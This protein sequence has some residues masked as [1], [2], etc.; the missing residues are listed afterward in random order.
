MV[1]LS[2]VRGLALLAGVC[3]A[4]LGLGQGWAQGLSAGATPDVTIAPKSSAVVNARVIDPAKEP[5]ISAEEKLQL[6]RRH[7]K[8]VFVLFQ[9]NRSFDFYFGSYPGADGLYAGPNGPY[10]PAQVAGFTQTIVNTDGTLGTVTPFR[11]PAT[12]TDAAGKTVP[13]FP[14]DIASVDHSHVGIARKIALDADGVAQNTEYALS[15]EGVRVVDGKPSK[16]PTL[17]RKQFGELVMSHVDC[18]TVPF[19]W[20]YADRFTLFDHFMDTIIGPSTPNAIAMIAGQ[21]GETQWMLH[22]EEAK[23]GGK[24]SGAVVPMLSDPQPYWGSMLDTAD[25][26]KQPQAVRPFGGV[27]KN[28]TFASLPLSFMGKDIKTTTAADYDPT[29]DLPD[30]HEDIEKIAGHGVSAVNWGWY[31]QGYDHEINDANGRASHDGYVAHHNAPQYFG[32]VANNPLA[33]THLHGLSDFFRDVEKGQLPKSGVFYVRGGYGNIEGW[34]PQDPNP[35]LAK[36]FF[37]NDDHPGYSDSQISEGL[38]AEEINAIAKSPYWSQSAI[39]I[40]YDE[41]DGEYDHARPRIRSHDAAG[42]PLEQGPRIPAI[43]ISPYAVAHGVSHVPTEHSSVIKFVDELFTLIPLADLPDE[44]RGR[45]IGQEKFGQENL[46]PADDKVADVG[47]MGSAFDV[48]RLEGKRAPL[49]AEYAIIPK[50]EIDAFPHDNGNGCRVLGITPTDSGIV[51][52][53]PKDFNPRPDS[54]PGVPTA[55]GWTP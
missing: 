17:E 26:L 55:G 19:L 22:P 25:R 45:E 24:G 38:L 29:F 3:G 47:D 15:E 21:G 30:V 48:L 9:E 28:L 7:I 27:S 39:I 13:L 35:K 42:L 23:T 5:N 11:I 36:V 34:K 20:R 40:T 32:Y 44:E 2:M 10:T 46:G 52:P 51:N 4:G 18:D 54:T 12:V 53:V 43:V 1:N 49:S 8:Y 14:A 37:G 6:M 31:Q 41:S 16:A 33:T 50:P